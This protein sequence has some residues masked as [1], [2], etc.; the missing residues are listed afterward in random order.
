LRIESKS[1][2]LGDAESVRVNI[3]F[4]AGD[5]QVT[6][7]AEKLLEAD[8]TYNVAKLKPEVKYTGD[9]LVVHQP[10]LDGVPSW[11]GIGDWRNEWSLRLSKQVPM[12]LSVKMGAGSSNLQLAGLSLS[13]LDVSL[14]AG[15]STID[16]SGDWARDLDVSIDSGAA[17]VTV[18]L[19][20]DVGVR[21][22]VES[23]PTITNAPELTKNGNIYTNDAY[24]KSEVTLQVVMVP[25]IGTINLAVAESSAPEALESGLLDIK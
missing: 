6:G 23:A 4:G 2:E 17:T 21:V 13:G 12:D 11:V 14:G 10:E 9:S 20:K 7:D 15:D 1:V 5:L 22:E 3:D 16:L 25:G 8:F 24:G 19:P 18:L